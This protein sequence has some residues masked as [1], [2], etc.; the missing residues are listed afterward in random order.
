[1]PTQHIQID[2]LSFRSV[3]PAQRIVGAAA[4]GLRPPRV[5]V[6]LVLLALWMTGGALWDLTTAPTVSR[7]GIA[8]GTLDAESLDQAQRIMESTALAVVPGAEV[9]GASA[10]ELTA[11]ILSTIDESS[12][13]DDRG[14]AESAVLAI[15][16]IRPRGTFASWSFALRERLLAL[17]GDAVSLN[18]SALPDRVGS[19]VWDLPRETIAVSWLFASYLVLLFTLGMSSI[20]VV[21]SRMNALDLSESPAPTLAQARAWGVAVRPSAVGAILVPLVGMGACIVLAAL[22]ALVGLVPVVGLLGGLTFGF[23]LLLGIVA[24]IIG[25][26]VTVALPFV[27]PAVACDA[28]DAVEAPQRALASVLSRPLHAVLHLGLGLVAVVLAVAATDVV[29]SCGFDAAV[30]AWTTVD[31]GQAIRSVGRMVPFEPWREP[32]SAD[33]GVIDAA[34]AW[35]IGFWRTIASALIGAAAVSTIIAASTR[36]WLFQRQAS[37]GQHPADILQRP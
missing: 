1:M 3:F 31:D 21:L 10:D 12:D 23:S 19:L 29:V 9:T 2:G 6:A 26:S 24:I 36:A 33:M 16:E 30:S 13:A 11:L 37:E 17:V 35:L 15:A 18:W 32:N 7:R 20:G 25:A 27:I 5:C 22:P 34:Q 8:F 14:R 4:A 28:A